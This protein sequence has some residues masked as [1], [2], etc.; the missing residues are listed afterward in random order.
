MYFFSNL[1]E[2]EVL[3]LSKLDWDMCAVIALDF[4]EHIIQRVQSLG[5]NNSD[6]I[7]R[8]SESLVAICS[9]NHTFYN[10]PPS[11]V[12]S[13]CVLATLRPFLEANEEDQSHQR[14]PNLQQALKVVEKITY[15]DQV[16]M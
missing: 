16:R 9:A 1:Q 6:V 8:H 3:L 11:L 2:W 12:A 5:W 7:R 10:L 14:M 4:V 13:A 15:H